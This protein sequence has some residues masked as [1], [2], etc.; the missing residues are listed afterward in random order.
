MGTAHCERLRAAVARAKARPTRV[1]VLLGG[2]DFW[3]NGIHLNL[4]EAAAQPADESWRNIEAM[5]DLVRE[6]VLT[7]DQLTIAA[8]QGNAG[9]GGVFL[10]LAADRGLRPRRRDPQSALQVDGQP[11]RLRVLDLPAA[12]AGRRRAGAGDHPEPA[13]AGR[14][15]GR[16]GGPH[17][18][19]LRRHA[20]GVSSPKSSGAPGA[21]GGCPDLASE[22]AAKRARRAADEAQAPLECYR[23]A[24]TRADASQLLRLRCELPCCA[25]AFRAQAATVADAAAPRAAPAP[26]RPTAARG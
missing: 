7:P 20:G 15:R 6:I 23:A 12:A 17:R 22:L 2:P 16:A 25:A 8:L 21:G 4:I 11:V 5:N 13:A 3:S 14:R 18:R 9:A 24:R 10:A 26:R 1:I 19:P